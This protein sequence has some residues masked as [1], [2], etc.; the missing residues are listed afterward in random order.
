M[1]LKFLGSVKN[2]V[3]QNSPT[4]PLVTAVQMLTSGVSTFRKPHLD[5]LEH[6]ISCI[7]NDLSPSPSG[8]DGLKDLEAICRAYDNPLTL[9]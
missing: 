7:I 3:T 1:Q 4:H 2:E 5:E 9:K 8:Q 6:F